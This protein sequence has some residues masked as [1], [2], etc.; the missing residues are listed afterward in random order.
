[1]KSPD[2][3]LGGLKLRFSF[4]DPN[5]G[6][7]NVDCGIGQFKP[8]TDSDRFSFVLRDVDGCPSIFPEGAKTQPTLSLV[9]NMAAPIPYSAVAVAQYFEAPI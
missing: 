8:D 1:M 2:L 6:Q 3:M 5:G 9:N 4:L 7:Q